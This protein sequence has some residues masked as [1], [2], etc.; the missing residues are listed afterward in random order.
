M[1]TLRC[2]GSFSNCIQALCSHLQW[3]D[4]KLHACGGCCPAAVA[5][6][7]TACMRRLL[8]C[9]SSRIPNCMHA[10]AV[11]LLQWQDTKLH[12]RM[13]A[14]LQWQVLNRNYDNLTNNLRG[15]PLLRQGLQKTVLKSVS[16]VI[17][18]KCSHVAWNSDK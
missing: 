15:L 11:A 14:L 9:C 12:A 16:S 5:G 18:N 6:Y 10:A 7:Q 3:K 4:T 17:M 2:S 8:T 1:R 13:D